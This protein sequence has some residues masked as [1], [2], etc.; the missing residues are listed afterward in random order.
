MAY[1]NSKYERIKAIYAPLYGLKY[2]APVFFQGI[3]DVIIKYDNATSTYIL[4]SIKRIKEFQSPDLSR[5]KKFIS[6]EDY[7][8]INKELSMI[9]Q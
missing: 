5:I 9:G 4:N 1:L 6:Y 3:D 8:R 2:V 7:K